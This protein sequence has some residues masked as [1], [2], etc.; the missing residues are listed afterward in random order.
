MTS[1]RRSRRLNER[2]SQVVEMRFFG[3][4]TNEQTADVLGESAKTVMREWQ[5]AQTWQS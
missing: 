2:K 1:S 5:L 3:G 4:L